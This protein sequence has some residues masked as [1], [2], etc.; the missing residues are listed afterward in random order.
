MFL[1]TPPTLAGTVDKT[2]WSSLSRWLQLLHGSI[3]DNFTPRFVYSNKTAS[4]TLRLEEAG[5]VFVD[6]GAA[7]MTL[8][9]P[10]INQAG[11]GT[12]YIFL[13][14]DASSNLLT[15]DANGTETIN[16]ALTYTAINAQYEGVAIVSTETEWIAWSLV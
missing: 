9:L 4:A 10:P 5:F 3:G 8:T 2:E 1:E 12:L 14:T 16:N 7:A 11:G 13:K 15:I 6:T